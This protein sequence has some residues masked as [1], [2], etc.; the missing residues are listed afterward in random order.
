MK[1]EKLEVKEKKNKTKLE[2]S[3]AKLKQNN[4]TYGLKTFQKIY[5]RNLIQLMFQAPKL[6]HS[7][8]KWGW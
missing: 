2:T 6:A 4:K 5:L 8:R 3:K 7:K 1:E